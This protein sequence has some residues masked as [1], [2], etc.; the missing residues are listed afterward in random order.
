MNCEILLVTH[1]KDIE[2]TKWNLKSI[3]K[4]A[5]GFSGLT[6]VVPKHER[7]AFEPLSSII[8]FSLRTHEL[9]GHLGAQTQKCLAD[10]HC[11][12]ADFVLHTDADCCLIEPVTPE[13]YFVDGKPVMLIEEFSRLHGN[14]WKPTVDK[15]LGGDAKYETMRRHPQVNPVGLYADMRE[16]I[17]KRHGITFEQYVIC[18]KGDYPWGFSEHCTLGAFALNSDW[19]DAYHWIDVGLVPHPKNKLHQS[20][21]HSPPE[22]E[23][24][25]P[26]GGRACPLDLFK[27]LGL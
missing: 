25:L 13:D 1:L 14:P 21:S 18:Q 20:W 24:D 4:F 9:S 23:Q 27:K 17:A 12:G 6:L 2:W 15:A 22:V 5:T 10:V 11:V 16:H 19:K 8:D 26:S 3:R 7:A